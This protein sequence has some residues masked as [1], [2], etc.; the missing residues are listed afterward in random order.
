[1]STDPIRIS[2]VG[3]GK[4]GFFHT[5]LLHRLGFL[6]SIVE[7]DLE[8]ASKIGK[9]FNIPTYSTIEEK[10]A[11]EVISYLPSL[12]TL[13]VEKPVAASV[14]EARA[15]QNKLAK[16]DLK[17][18]VGHVEVYNPVIGRIMGIL[19]D[20]VLGK[21]RSILFQ[22]RGAVAETR[23]GS[24]GDVYEDIGV[25]DFDV[26]MRLFP[27]GKMQLFSSA[28]KLE[29]VGNSSIIVLTSKEQDFFVTFLMS[30]E[31]AGK[32]RT[33]DIE[34]T[35]ATL[36]ANL[37]TQMLE[38]RSLEIARGEKDTSSIRIPFSNGEQIKVYGEPLLTEMWN[39][40]D[41]IRGDAEPLV[42]VEDGINALKLVEA[43]RK[44]IETG[45]VIE[46]RI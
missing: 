10:V 30:R 3:T 19:K 6:D 13:L 15:F 26:A 16:K 25:H 11:L 31:Y 8:K 42:T 39:L 7:P 24:I 37:L 32:L 23:L 1:M 43:A 34:G 9:Q 38:L 36:C 44:S 46:L 12:K 21:P 28:L 5:R 29:N 18:I 17:V 33:I 2:V 35:K 20:N 4:M 14:E 45:K 41:C 22:R 40:V 27:K